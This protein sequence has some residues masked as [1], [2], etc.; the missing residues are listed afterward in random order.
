[1]KQKNLLT[2]AFAALLCLSLCACAA[3]NAANTSS[4]EKDTPLPKDMPAN[5][6]F[7]SGAGAWSTELSL[8]PDGTFSGLFHDSNMGESGPG[9]PNGTVYYCKFTG[10]FDQIEKIDDLTYSLTLASL[11]LNGSDVGTAEI[12]L[13]DGIR[14]ISSDPYGLSAVGSTYK[15][16]LPDTDLSLLSDEFL[17]WWPLRYDQ[18]DPA[19]KHTTLSCWGLLNEADGS[20]F[21][22]LAE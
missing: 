19:L 17:N 2:I 12:D 7:E 8:L 15:L 11:T 9:Y 18:S 14:Y 10:K 20:G 16:Y 13:K 6:I 3:V 4:V 21:F 22:S 1:M 5:F